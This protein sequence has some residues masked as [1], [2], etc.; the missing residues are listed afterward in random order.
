M[1][2]VVTAIVAARAMRENLLPR[3][4]PCFDVSPRLDLVGHPRS[5]EPSASEKLLRVIWTFN[6]GRL[7]QS[8]WMRA[9]P[10]IINRDP[11]PARQA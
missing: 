5:A 11:M 1:T 10:D 7:E 2:P 3:V 8:V 6:A 9:G 4:S